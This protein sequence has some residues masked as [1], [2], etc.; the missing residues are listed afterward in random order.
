MD[1]AVPLD[2]LR[3]MISRGKFEERIDQRGFTNTGFTGK[4][5]ELCTAR[6]RRLVNVI[7]AAQIRIAPDD[8][9]RAIRIRGLAYGT[10]EKTITLADDGFEVLRISS[11]V[12]QRGSNFADT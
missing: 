3:I 9:C 11:V 7:Q 5:H 1:N 8:P 12:P 4:Q 10:F 6:N 2:H